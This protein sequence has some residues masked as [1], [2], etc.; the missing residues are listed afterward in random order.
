MDARAPDL[1]ERVTGFRAFRRCEDNWLMGE[2]SSDLWMPGEMEAR[3]APKS[4]LWPQFSLKEE[5][6]SP[7][8]RCHCGLHA[9]YSVKSL[10]SKADHTIAALVSCSGVVIPHFDGFRAERAKIHVL[11]DRYGRASTD[12]VAERYDVPVVRTLEELEERELEF[13]SPMPLSVRSNG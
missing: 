4:F 9:Y 3:C 7:H 13:G 2:L 8:L 5:H 12:A 10:V 6:N 1:V 11:C